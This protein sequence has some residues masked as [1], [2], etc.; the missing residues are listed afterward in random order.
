MNIGIIIFIISVIITGVSALR[1]KSHEDRQNQRPNQKPSNE[2]H[3]E[4]GFFE[5]L[6]K[7]FQEISD[8]LNDE[9]EKKQSKPFE[10]SLPPLNEDWNENEKKKLH[11]LKKSKILHNRNVKQRLLMNIRI[12]LSQIRQHQEMIILK[13]LS[14]NLN[15]M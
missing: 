3:Q 14:K 4:G 5:K 9:P 12:F 2:Q 10:T 6:E 8:E 13:N 7:T 11:I 1:D 15:K